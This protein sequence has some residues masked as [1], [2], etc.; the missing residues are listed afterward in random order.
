[1]WPFQAVLSLL[2]PVLL[3]FD[4]SVPCPARPAP[5]YWIPL[6][7]WPGLQGVSK[8][9]LYVFVQSSVIDLGLRSRIPRFPEGDLREA[10][11]KDRPSPCVVT[12]QKGR[13][14]G[15]TIRSRVLD[16]LDC[17]ACNACKPPERRSQLGPSLTMSFFDIVRPI[18][19][20]IS[21]AVAGSY[22]V[23]RGHDDDRSRRIQR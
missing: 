18:A 14:P 20:H 6:L 2:S 5:S 23:R 16:V 11:R 15:S 3:L 13:N 10:D 8:A 21:N 17:N 12:N 4:R 7:V 19:R 1:M 9:P 22:P